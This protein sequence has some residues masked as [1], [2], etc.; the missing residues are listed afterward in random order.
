MIEMVFWFVSF[1]HQN[2]SSI[3]PLSRVFRTAAGAPAAKG[4]LRIKTENYR[5]WMKFAQFT[6]LICKKLFVSNKSP[7]RGHVVTDISREL[8]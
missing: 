7:L 5:L 1:V 4:I 6:V 2:I 3:P 8:C